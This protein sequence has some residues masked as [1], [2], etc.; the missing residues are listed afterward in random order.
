MST[1]PELC[2][3]ILTA[4]DPEW[5]KEFTDRLV[6]D[7]LCAA[8]HN[9]AP[10]RIT[11]WRDGEIHTTEEGRAALHTRKSLI[12]NI[13]ERVKREHPYEVP[14]LAATSISSGNPDYLAW[15][16][17]KTS[18]GNAL[19]APATAVQAVG[20]PT[21][22]IR[23]ACEDDLRCCRSTSTVQQ[24]LSCRMPSDGTA[25]GARTLN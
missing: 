4:P 21:R 14:G 18:Q 15:I 11:Y 12:G 8:A 25:R 20:N 22:R 19:S 10:I 9:F 5:L 24:Q 3:V 6:A 23:P 7:R 17:T 2:E 16:A 1:D 13:V